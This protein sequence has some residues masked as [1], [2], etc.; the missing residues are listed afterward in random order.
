MRT[1]DVWRAPSRD[2]RELSEVKGA[3]SGDE[4]VN[5]KQGEGVEH[6]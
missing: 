3:L 6:V 2:E 4:R 5:V 1:N